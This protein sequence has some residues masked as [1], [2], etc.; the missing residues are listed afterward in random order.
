[1]CARFIAPNRLFKM[2]STNIAPNVRST[3]NER[4]GA[5][6]IKNQVGGTFKI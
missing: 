5:T 1:M 6:E 2:H 4:K 3:G